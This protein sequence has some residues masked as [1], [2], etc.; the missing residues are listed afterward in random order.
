M[1]FVVLFL[2]ALSSLRA[3]ERVAIDI[4]LTEQRAHLIIN[5]RAVESAPISSGRREYPTPPGTYR[6]M[7][8]DRNHYSSLYGKIVNARGETLVGDADSSMRVPPG[9]RFV[10]APMRYFLR[11]T[12]GYGLHAGYL[13][14]YAASHGC[15]RMPE[16]KARTFFEAVSLGTPIRVYGRA[17]RWEFGIPPDRIRRAVPVGR[18]S[19]W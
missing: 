17:P 10:R 1:V 15:V 8:K 13:P 5:G 3:A 6:V 7:E 14:G 2:T 16:D 18:Q 4:D 9:G 19:R 12:G 11:F